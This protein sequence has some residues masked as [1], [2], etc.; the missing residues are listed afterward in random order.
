MPRAQLRKQ[1]YKNILTLHSV[2]ASTLAVSRH[3]QGHLEE[4]FTLEH[5]DFDNAEV[6]ER[7]TRF[8]RG[9]A[10]GLR[11]LS[12]MLSMHKSRGPYIQWQKCNQFFD[13][14]LSWPDRDFRH[15]YRVGRATF[16]RLVQILEQNPIFESTGR[17]PQRP[18]RYQLACF[19]L[20]YGIVPHRL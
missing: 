20:R 18:V 8:F 9:T 19:L 16:D 6:N 3:K 15:E 13:I 1:D 7:L 10:T 12:L 5:Q 11:A 17:K 2:L 4:L 14:S